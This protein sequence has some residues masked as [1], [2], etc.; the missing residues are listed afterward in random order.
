M[1]LYKQLNLVRFSVVVC[2]FESNKS[3]YSN[4]FLFVYYIMQSTWFQPN[5]I[6]CAYPIIKET[7]PQSERGYKT[8]NKY[9]QFPPIMSDGRSITASWQHDAVTNATLIKENNIRSNWEYRQYLTNNAVN[10][11]EQNFRESSND[12]GYINRF[13]TVPN[14]QSNQFQG[15]SG[16]AIYESVLDNKKVIGHT[17]S[18]LKTNYLSREDLQ[19]RKFSPVI[20]QDQ[21]IKTLGLPKEIDTKKATK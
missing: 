18:D 12:L 9:L 10:V 19:S 3:K 15:V 16:P 1:R 8:N 2:E 13:A 7:V 11:A 21:F 14:I 5:S 6:Q 17:T 4:I 20:T